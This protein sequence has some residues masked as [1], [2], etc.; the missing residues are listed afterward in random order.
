MR[1]PTQLD[2][3]TTVAERQEAATARALGDCRARLDAKTGRLEQLENYY[4]EYTRTLSPAPG[5]QLTPA[6]LASH[7]AF[8]AQLRNVIDDETGAH[9]KLCDELAHHQVHYGAARAHTQGL[10]KLGERREHASMLKDLRQEQS[11]SDELAARARSRIW[12]A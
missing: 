1:R 3:L 10:K 6:L 7:G 8:L 2:T 4:L 12:R 11:V 5:Q 9:S